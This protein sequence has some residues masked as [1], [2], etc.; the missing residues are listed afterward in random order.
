[1]KAQKRRVSQKSLRQGG[2]H[3]EKVV[4]RMERQR[5]MDRSPLTGV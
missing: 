5:Q 3:P 2:D 4:M 1:M